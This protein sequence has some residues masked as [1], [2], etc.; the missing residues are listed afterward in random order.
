MKLAKEMGFDVAQVECE[1]IAVE[2]ILYIKKFDR[3]IIND[4]N[5]IHRKHIIDT[6]Q[7]LNIPM[8]GI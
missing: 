1:Y 3:E 5:I 2:S 8:R 4:D 7:A 6:V